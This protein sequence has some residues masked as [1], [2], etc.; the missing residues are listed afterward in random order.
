MSEW[1]NEWMNVHCVLHY[2]LSLIQLTY[3][4]DMLH[5]WMNEWMNV[6]CVLHDN[7]SN[8]AYISNS[9]VTWINE[10]MNEW[11]NE[12]VNECLFSVYYIIISV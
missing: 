11:M 9:H 10:S 1:M 2:N 6:Q 7:L 12:W 4:I 5:E 3:R 8:S